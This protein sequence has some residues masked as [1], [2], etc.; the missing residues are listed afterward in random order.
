MATLTPK[1]NDRERILL[2]VR[3]VQQVDRCGQKLTGEV[4]YLCT[5]IGVSYHMG[6]NAFK[7]ISFQSA[8]RHT[9]ARTHAAPH[10]SCSFLCLD[11]LIAAPLPSLAFGAIVAV[12][13]GHLSGV[14]Q[15]VEFVA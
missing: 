11:G 10:Q 1:Y 8:S 6:D 2:H 5:D 13:S 7:W 14:L 3:V 15:H 9:Y 4:R 12:Q